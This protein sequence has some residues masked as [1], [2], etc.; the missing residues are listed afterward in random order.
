MRR[1]LLRIC[2][3]LPIC[4]GSLLGCNSGISEKEPTINIYCSNDVHGQIEEMDDRMDIVN[5]GT[6]MKNKGK[7]KNTLLIDSGDS[8]Q[9]SIHSNHNHGAMIN[10]I[11]CEA[12]FSAR[13]IG[14]H[15]FDWGVEYL[16][17]NTAR[18][19]NGYRVPVLAANV[20]N[21]NFDTKEVGNI[22]QSDIGQ[23]TVTYK[24]NNGLKVG[25]V[26]TIGENQITSIT[27]I[28]T[29]DL[30]F[31]DHVEVIKE[32]AQK[33]KKEGCQVV[34]ASVHAGQEEVY[35]WGLS[36][37]VDLFLCAHT[38]RLETK[39]ENGVY[40]AQFGAYGENIGNVKL[41][42]SRSEKKV[43]KT[44]IKTLDK[45]TVKREVGSQYDPEIFS[46]YNRYS[47]ACKAESS[48]LVAN[49]VVGS[50]PKGN[51]AVNLMCKAIMDETKKQGY[52]DVI[53]SYCNTGRN[54]LPNY[55]W[56][57]ADLYLTFP[58]DNEIFI[59]E[60]KGRDISREILPYNNVCYS[61]T[62]DGCYESDK[63]YKIACIDYLLYH[64]NTSRNYDYFPTFNESSVAKLDK[65]YREIL[66]DWLIDNGYNQGKELNRDDY[67]SYNQLFNKGYLTEIY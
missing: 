41:T 5:Y 13:T 64:T 8:W 14:N 51:E 1:S 42:Y 37:Y 25:I 38:H 66:R 58:F 44:E 23:K 59:T 6:F 15:D 29:K 67:S 47:S 57:Y 22:Q 63:Y 9:G 39:T 19:Y 28:Y 52:D 32:E 12:H 36:K 61:D 50:F 55:T 21:Y 17:A 2:A 4:L 26:G 45:K 60:I 24:L 53:L 18:E 65:N 20:Y 10:D 40:F 49:N 56:T 35:G 27:S 43:I 31:V 7:E 16:K 30:T 54:N 3:L 46:I 11:M 33:L 34:I 48:V 62:F